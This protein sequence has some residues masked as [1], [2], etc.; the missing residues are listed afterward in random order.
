MSGVGQDPVPFA[1]IK[2]PPALHA[3][4]RPRLVNDDAELHVDEIV[5]G[6]SEECRSLCERRST[7]PRD[8][9]ARR[10]SA[11]PRWQRPTPYRR[12]RQKQK[13]RSPRKLKCAAPYH[14]YSHRSHVF[15]SKAYV[16]VG[17]ELLPNMHALYCACDRR[18]TSILVVCGFDSDAIRRD[19]QQKFSLLLS[20]HKLAA[21]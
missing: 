17:L 18:G 20:S 1:F 8:R 12:G 3:Y 21:L 6:I 15:S 2:M 9:M 4:Q 10:T 11:Q 19:R 5:V 13:M 7:G 16:A 14:W